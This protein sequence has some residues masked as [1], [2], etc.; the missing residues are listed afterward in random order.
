MCELTIL[1]IVSVPVVKSIN[2]SHFSPFSIFSLNFNITDTN[3]TPQFFDVK[4]V[5]LAMVRKDK[6]EFLS[7]VF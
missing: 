3:S 1:L 5:F 6:E 7:E 2:L 4:I